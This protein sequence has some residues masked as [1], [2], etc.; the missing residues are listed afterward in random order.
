MRNVLTAGSLFSGIGGFEAG[1]E[2]AGMQ[3]AFQVELDPACQRVLEHHWPD[4]PRFEDVTHVGRSNLPDVDVLCGGFPCQDLSVA[5]RR[6]GLSGERS[7]LWWQFHRVLDGL[8]PEW[9]VIENVPGLLSSNAG[10]DMATLLSS[11]GQLGYW[12]AYRVLDAQYDGVPQRRRRVFIVG[13]SG[14]WT[15]PATV[16]FEPESRGGDTPPRRTAGQGVAPSTASGTVSSKWAKGSGGPAGDEAYNLIPEVAPTLGAESYSPSKSSSGQMVDWM[17][18]HTL[19]SE[20]SD[21][22]E[23]GTGRGTPLVAQSFS[24]NQR[25]EVLT[26]DV[27][28]NITNGG[29]NP[30]QGYPAVM[31]GVAVRRLTPLECLRLQGFPDNWLDL[32]N[33]SD[34]AKYR[35]VGNA[36]CVPVAQWIG[37]RIMEAASDR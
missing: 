22:S 11:L 29:G 37:E 25:A 21:A 36:V 3:I 8:R 30:G 7:G 26:S 35:M 5:G 33:L 4:V 23:D 27:V 1:L 28:R 2:R 32:P 15:A 10:R 18:A 20:G 9:I 16:L 13:H 14:E 6:T 31:D 24:E 19:S 12:W 34:S 17:I